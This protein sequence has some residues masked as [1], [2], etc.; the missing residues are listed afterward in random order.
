[1]AAVA[2]ASFNCFVSWAAYNIGLLSFDHSTF[3]GTDVFAVSPLDAT[4]QGPYDDLSKL[5][6]GYVITRGRSSNLDQVNAGALNVDIRDPTGL[7][8]PDNPT[9]PLYGTLEDRL[10]PIKLTASYLGVTYGRFYGWVRRFHWE[11]QGRRGITQLECVDLFYWLDRANPTIASTGVTTTGAAIGKILDAVGAIDPALRDLDVGDT[12]PDFSA[13]GTT[14]GLA[15][16]QGLLEAERGMFFVAA[17]GKATYRSR[18]SR[19]TK[20]S[21]FT[22]VDHMAGASP[23]VDWDTVFDRITVKRT[24]NGYTA[25]AFDSTVVAKVGY[26]D[27]PEIDTA[28]LSANTQADGLAQWLLAQNTA[29]RP[30]M[31]DFTI[32]NRESALLVQQL[33]R[34]LV[35]R[36]TVQ[37]ARG[38]TSGDFHIDQISET[39]DG[40]SGRL[41]SKY[42]LSKA[43][44]GKAAQFDVADF[45][46]AY[47]FVY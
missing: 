6:H 23:G 22:F 3:G 12:I 35:D 14:S 41:T 40:D 21:S 36:I 11:P 19:M 33:Q 43:A 7:Y 34:E 5:F 42:L 9:G 45:S 32:D 13:N 38:G 29:P 15:L 16:I 31:R 25:I 47:E 17:N 24:Q 2:R 8:N 1:M 44:P 26:N 18:A 20:T 37:A 4:F 28:Y 10:H 27:L 46:G 39:L 30:P